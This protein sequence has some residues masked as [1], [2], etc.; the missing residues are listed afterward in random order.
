MR[1]RYRI[2]RPR[3]NRP[4]GQPAQRPE[5]LI[6]LSGWIPPITQPRYH[7]SV[8]ITWLGRNCFRLKGREGIVLTDPPP[9]NSGYKIGKQAAEVVTL[10]NREEAGYSNLDAV[11]GKPVVLDAPGEYEIGGILVEGHATKRADGSRNTIFV[12]ELDGIRVGHLGLLAGALD[13]AMMEQLKVE[14]LL[15]PVG[16]GNAIGGREA[17][18]VMTAID[19]NIAI[20]MNYKTDQEK[21][22]LEPLERFLKETGAKSEPQP[23]LQVSKSGLPSDLAVMVL[24]PRQ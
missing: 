17:Q 9:P 4:H 3:R 16:G 1:T 18:D 10:S 20:P 23:K 7:R 11:T 5:L 24:Q 22:D 12:C 13:T 19:P 2:R 15:L 14:V 21:L 6:L 8:E